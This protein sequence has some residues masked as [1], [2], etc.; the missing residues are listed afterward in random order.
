MNPLD[1]DERSR[2]LRTIAQA[3]RRLVEL[4]EHPQVGADTRFRDVFADAATGIAIIDA[5]GRI[6]DANDAYCRMLGYAPGDLAGVE[7]QQLVHEDDRAAY[8]GPLQQ[9]LAGDR[10]SVVIEH[11]CASTRGDDVWLRTSVSALRGDGT[12]PASILAVSEDISSRRQAE[13]MLRD[14]TALLRVAG[15][16]ARV[17]GWAVSLPDHE[18]YWSDEICD[19]L[20]FPH[21]VVAGV[22]E[23]L[24]LHRPGSRERIEA[25]LHACLTH[26]RPFDL[27]L[28][29]VSR[30]GRPLWVRASG[31]ADRDE[32]G[33]IRQAIGALQDIT[34]QRRTSVE[35]AESEERFRFVAEA[36]ADAVWDW[37]LRNDRIWWSAGIEKLF[38][39]A[40]AEL[41]TDSAAWSGRI[42]PDDIGRVLDSVRR[43]QQGGASAWQAQYRFRRHDDSYATV[44]DRGFV[45][46]DGDGQAVRMVGG[47]ADISERLS[48]EEHLRQSQ[49][50]ESIGQL[51]GGIAHDFNNL[52]TVI[53]G[54]SELLCEQLPAD[55]PLQPIA[56]MI[57]AAAQRG[58]DLTQ[59][60]LAFARRQALEPRAIDVAALADGME[61]LLRGTLGRHIDLAI[62]GGGGRCLAMVDPA[63]LENALL[64]LCINARDAMPDG[65]RLRIDVGRS[66]LPAAASDPLAD[67]LPGEY[68]R[69]AV[70]DTGHGIPAELLPRVIEPFFT[71]K[72]KGKG[73][74][75]GLSMVYGF[76]RQ[77]RGHLEITSEAGRGTTVTVWLPCLAA[78][79]EPVA[80]SADAV[81][82]AHVGGGNE[83]ILL[84]EDDPLVRHF[85]SNQLVRLGYCVLVSSNARE[86]L[87]RIDSGAA[88]DLLFTDVVMPGGMNGRELAEAARA[89]RPGLRVLYCSGYSQDALIHQGRVNADVHL[90]NKPYRREDLARR[91]RAVLDARP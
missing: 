72:G 7:L 86:A 56:T 77:S 13:A 16:M 61:A 85:A 69:I 78:D 89:R 51:T 48:L 83:T 25:A 17:G 57:A 22:E 90:L 73:T 27:E 70:S 19:L 18:V 37:D 44:V 36:T 65:G 8:R 54:N 46:R 81:E 20:D 39:L 80:A 47:M 79:A 15:R 55:S 76:V 33:R 60:L 66:E 53:V 29:M 34:E 49:R 88:I 24:A 91:V 59:R 10:A 68:V 28:E 32:H 5:T 11:R 50:L 43:V 2:L 82:P 31:E 41:R 67:L 21:G 45:I 63:Q 87:A 42:H 71:T 58:A 62:G 1:D 26:G 4:G 35:L 12:Q 52:L 14:R 38:G 75:L 64:N 3:R 6:E 9:V 23:G 74:G 30:T 40:L 84:V